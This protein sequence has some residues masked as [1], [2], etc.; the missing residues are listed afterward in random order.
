M[1]AGRVLA[2]RGVSASVERSARYEKVEKI[3]FCLISNFYSIFNRIM[4]FQVRKYSKMW[5]LKRRDENSSI[6]QRFKS[7]W[8][9]TSFWKR[10]I[11][12]HSLALETTKC[13]E[14]CCR[15]LK[16]RCLHH[17]N[18]KNLKIAVDA[19]WRH[20]RMFPKACSLKVLFRTMSQMF[21]SRNALKGK[22]LHSR[23]STSGHL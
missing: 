5:L 2:F 19:F 13:N 4:K 22:T 17:R 6:H 23:I 3:S 20:L 1:H 11:F 21:Q 8:N 9:V 16:F 18:S 7:F 10:K 15:I 14:R 12:V